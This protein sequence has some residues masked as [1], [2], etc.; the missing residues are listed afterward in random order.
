MKLYEGTLFDL[1]F[2]LYG[3]LTT[4][5]VIVGFDSSPLVIWLVVDLIHLLLFEG[6]F[7]IGLCLNLPSDKSSSSELALHLTIDNPL[8]DLVVL[9]CI[10]H[11][12]KAHVD[13]LIY[14]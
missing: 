4:T 13:I 2:G 9:L 1:G 3:Y 8:I 11:R 10:W 5:V 7:D 12:S 6:D 14:F